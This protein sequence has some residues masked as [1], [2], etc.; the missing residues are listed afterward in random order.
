MPTPGQVI[1]CAFIIALW[2]TVVVTPLMMQPLKKYL[3]SCDRTAFGACVVTR[4]AVAE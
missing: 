1:G 3:P 2:V 4:A